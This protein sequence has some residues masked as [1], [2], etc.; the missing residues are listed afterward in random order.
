MPKTLTILEELMAVT[1]L[2]RGKD[3]EPVFLKALARKIADLP[4]ATFNGLSAD[5]QSWYNAA[6]D[7][8]DDGKDP[9]APPE[10][11][12]AEETAPRR[13]KPA[14]AA[15]AEEAPPAPSRRKAA[16]PAA[17]PAPTARKTAKPKAAVK[18]A[19]APKAA[20]KKAAPKTVVK[21]A[22]PKTAKKERKGRGPSQQSLIREIVVD[23]RDDMAEEKVIA[24][25]QAKFPN[26]TPGTVSTARA[27]ARALIKLLAS[28]GYLN[29]NYASEHFPS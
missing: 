23:N 12:V 11:Q 14:E 29:R 18:K 10:P 1:S 5:A 8:M 19:A 26:A 4:D 20:P 2:K 17:E 28:K 21:A 15:A 16:E 22:V 7:A 9:V 6:C 27:N 13:R 24:K 25:V 3:A